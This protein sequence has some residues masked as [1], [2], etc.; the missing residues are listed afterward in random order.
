MPSGKF[1]EVSRAFRRR[2]GCVLAVREGLRFTFAWN[3]FWAG[4]VVAL[5]GVWLV[6]RWL[7]LWGAVGLAAAAAAGGDYRPPQSPG[8]RRDPRSP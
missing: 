4:A 3:M 5:R 7:L 1:A 2:L 6:D 8:P